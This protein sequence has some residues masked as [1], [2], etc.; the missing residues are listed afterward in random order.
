MQASALYEDHEGTMTE[1][2]PYFICPES[3][4][5]H[6]R[7]NWELCC[8]EA[9]EKV[10]EPRKDVGVKLEVRYYY[11]NMFGFKTKYRLICHQ[12]DDLI[13]PP[14]RVIYKDDRPINPPILQCIMFYST[15]QKKPWDVTHRVL[16]YAGPNKD[17]GTTPIKVFEMF[18]IDDPESLRQQ[19][20]HL[21]V[22]D[23]WNKT[24]FGMDDV[25]N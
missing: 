17:F 5:L 22:I 14:H 3:R 1:V 21:L 4:K 6:P 12:G 20:S 10:D 11:Q 2:T 13:I 15:G 23:L 18:P 19:F 7:D 16:K 24:T 9:L 25:I 8:R